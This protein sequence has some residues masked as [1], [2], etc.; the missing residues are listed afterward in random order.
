MIQGVVCRGHKCKCRLAP[1]ATVQ[2][3]LNCIS[4]ISTGPTVFVSHFLVFVFQVLRYLS[5]ISIWMGATVIVSHS[6]AGWHTML[7][8]IIPLQYATYAN[9]PI[10]TNSGANPKPLKSKNLQRNAF[11]FS[12]V[13]FCNQSI[14][15]L[16]ECHSP[17]MQLHTGEKYNTLHTRD[18][19]TITVQECTWR[20]Q[21][22]NVP[23]KKWKKVS[24]KISVPK[25]YPPSQSRDA[26]N[27]CKCKM[28]PPKK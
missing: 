23:P 18:V 24:Q 8:V 15:D 9:K 11:S 27:E 21:M 25:N 19:P 3:T 26:H 13:S 4:C 17:V 22:P 2:T 16:E 10:E 6:R 20:V 5:S 7:Q 1:P 12:Q 14:G 28:F